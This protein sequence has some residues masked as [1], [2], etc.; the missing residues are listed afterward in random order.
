MANEELTNEIYKKILEIQEIYAKAYPKGDYL[1][2]F[3]SE[4]YIRFNNKYW[5]EN[6]DFPINFIQPKEN[7]NG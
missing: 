1:S 3:I 4:N 6:K 5:D 2:M 7:N